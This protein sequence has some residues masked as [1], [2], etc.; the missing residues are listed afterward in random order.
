M[1]SFPLQQTRAK[2]T[3]EDK[4]INQN[5]KKHEKIFVNRKM[6]TW[7]GNNNHNVNG[8]DVT[9]NSRNNNKNY[10]IKTKDS[11]GINSNIGKKSNK[12]DSITKA[13]SKKGKGSG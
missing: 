1:F 3:K 10:N 9:T 11:N 6:H 4:I 7:L 13:R 12:Y 8:V 2:E 5:V